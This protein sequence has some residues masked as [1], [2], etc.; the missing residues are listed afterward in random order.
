MTALDRE[1]SQVAASDKYQGKCST[2]SQ[3]RF[4]IYQYNCFDSG[5]FFS[6][7]KG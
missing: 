6:R 3:G 1:V 5:T 7:E 4:D 2:S